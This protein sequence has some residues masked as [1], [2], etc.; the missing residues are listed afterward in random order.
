MLRTNWQM[1]VLDLQPS[2]RTVPVILERQAD[3]LGDK[4]FVAIDGT[5]LSYRD[6]REL[7]ATFAGSLAEAAIS[8][9]DRVAIMSGNRLEVLAA[10]AGCA[11]IGAILVPLNPA[12]RGPQLAHVLTNAGPKALALSANLAPQLDAVPRPPP[13][14]ERIWL[15]DEG[16]FSWN[17]MTAERFPSP[18][19]AVEPAP[20]MPGDT[21]AILY[22]SGTSGPSK[23]VCCPH[24]QSYWWGRSVGE[25]LRVSGDDILHTTLPLYHS[26]AFNAIMHAGLYGAQLVVAPRFS[27]SK[28]WSRLAESRATVTYLLGAAASML[29]ARE[30]APHERD[31]DVRVALSPATPP[32]LQTNFRDRFGVELVDAFGM[33]ET[34]AVIGPCEGKMRPGSMGRVMPGFEVRVVDDQDVDVPDGVPGELVMRADEPFAFATGYWRTPEE[35]VATSRNLW[36]HSGDRVVRD[37]EGY[38]WFRDRLKDSIRRRGENISAWEVEQALLSHSGVATCAVIPVPSELGEDEVM[39]YVVAKPGHELSG[40]ELVR[41]CEPLLPYFAI[42]RYIDFVPELPLTENG[43]VRKFILRDRGITRS[44]WDREQAGYVASDSSRA[45]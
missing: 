15:L 9:G 14:L 25:M 7:A 4:P 40:P 3:A 10:W 19:S 21:L 38:F 23:G 37:A 43:K 24:A 18:G 20:V 16:A 2:E 35:T 31:H 1:T 33:T 28:F 29:A 17:G 8:R 39:A 42:P 13:E 22:T 32:A 12:S 44:T 41:F 26:N 30:I 5:V 6:V 45:R 11:W 36:F 27:V 34:N